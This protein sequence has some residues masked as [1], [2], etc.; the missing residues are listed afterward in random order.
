M[1]SRR[2]VFALAVSIAVLTAR[3]VEAGLIAWNYEWSA[4]PIVINAD[5]LGPHSQP[6]GGITLTPGAITITGGTPGVALGSAAVTA[7][8]LTAFTFAPSPNGEPY[9]FTNAAYNLGVKLTDVASGQWGVLRFSGVFNGSLTASIEHIQMRFT[10]AT[11]QRLHLGHNFYTVS[12]T[13]Y[14]PPGPPSTG[15]EGKISA[16]VNVQPASVP[17]PSALLLAAVGLAAAIISRRPD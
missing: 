16:L 6:T 7:V 17:E 14:M 8:D 3:R 2:V 10:S 4:H 11:R 5:P 9:H 13:T 12:L 15:E 1:P